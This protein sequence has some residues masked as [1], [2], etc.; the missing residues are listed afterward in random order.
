MLGGVSNF[1]TEAEPVRVPG[2]TD[3]RSEGRNSG[4]WLVR[5]RVVGVNEVDADLR[6]QVLQ[7]V[8]V[9][10]GFGS[11]ENRV[12]LGVHG[13]RKSVRVI[14][15][16]HGLIQ[17]DEL[18]E[19]GSENGYFSGELSPTPVKGQVSSNAGLLAQIRIANF[20]SERRRMRSIG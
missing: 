15:I 18:L 19:L 4:Q 6:G 16:V 11:V 20:E 2:Q 14:V 10:M 8:D 13:N 12:G 7:D 5:L 17:E 1:T 9:G 3:A